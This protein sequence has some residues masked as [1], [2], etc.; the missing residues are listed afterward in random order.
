MTVLTDALDWDEIIPLVNGGAG[1]EVE[2]S[3]VAPISLQALQHA[4]GR[5]FPEAPSKHVP[6]E[7]LIGLTATHRQAGKV[8]VLTNGCFDLLHAG[9][10]GCLEE[11]SR[12][13]DVLIVAINSDAGV[14]QLKG[15]GR[16]LLALDARTA[17]LSA[18]PCVT[19][20]V[21]FGEPTPHEIIRRLRPDVLAKGGDYTPDQVVGRELVTAY[22]GRVC[23]TGKF[24]SPSTSQIA[25]KLQG[26][27]RART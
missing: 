22:G 12:L 23:V 25:E 21:V 2:R 15:A 27:P 11:A 18:L 24:E 7:H 3:R 19:H 10:V 6:L 9:H 8:I 26:H 13:G 1:P 14:R 20:V 5:R 16:P 4:L 17:L